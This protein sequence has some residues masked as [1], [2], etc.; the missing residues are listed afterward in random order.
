MMRIAGGARGGGVGE[1]ILTTAFRGTCIHGGL[2]HRLLPIYT[3]QLK[4]SSRDYLTIN[5]LREI[6][7]FF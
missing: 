7:P 5:I 3:V 4:A 6:T 2:Y 1:L